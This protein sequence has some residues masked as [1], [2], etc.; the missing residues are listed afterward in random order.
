MKNRAD[1]IR[2]RYQGMVQNHKQESVT[3]TFSP[4][5]D[6]SERARGGHPLFSSQGLLFRLMAS[7]C[8]FLVI[9]II[10]KNPSE[11]LL[12]IK[13]QVTNV[14]QEEFKFA[15]VSGWYED[16]FGEPLALFP[17][18][19]KVSKTNGEVKEQTYALPANTKVLQSFKDNGKG[20]LLETGTNTEVST[21]KEG[22][23][24][25]V[26]DKDKVGKTVVVQHFDGSESWYGK[27][28][29]IDKD[30]KLYNYID[31]GTSLGK[32]S[33]EEGSTTGLFYFAFKKD[34]GS[35]VDPLKV[36]SIE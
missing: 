8:M 35:F 13:E 9:G 12:P 18:D 14:F 34:D 28:D 21:I 15:V 20:I 2:K 3:N 30:I 19:N 27:L 31:S 36:L 6:E 16:T 10:F 24:I 11:N 25:F 17:G 23:V 33:S 4:Y 1:E 32:V 26:G 5:R 7:V 22:F 29:E